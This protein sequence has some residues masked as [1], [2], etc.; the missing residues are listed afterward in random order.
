MWK[1][2]GLKLNF[3]INCELNYVK[4]ILIKTQ[5]KNG[6]LMIGVIYR[7]LVSYVEDIENFFNVMSDI[8]HNINHKKYSNIEVVVVVYFI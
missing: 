8:L 2:F 7:H 6:P 1:I 4:N 5:T 3:K